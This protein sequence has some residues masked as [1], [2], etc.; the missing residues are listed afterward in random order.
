MEDDDKVVPLPLFEDHLP[1]SPPHTINF[2]EKIKRR[3]SLTR[4]SLQRSNSHPT[5]SLD[6]NKRLPSDTSMAR[7]NRDVSIPSQA[8]MPFSTPATYTFPPN[9]TT[10]RK[11]ALTTIIPPPPRSSRS[12]SLSFVLKPTSPQHSR[13]QSSTSFNPITSPRSS[14]PPDFLLDDDPFAA[15]TGFCG[16]AQVSR[17]LS[18]VRSPRLCSMNEEEEEAIGTYRSCFWL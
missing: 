2:G 4:F 18:G 8:S 7:H 3:L 14:P 10:P 5:R 9:D 16:G 1:K 12:P 17:Q 11:R 15:L 6:I 13:K